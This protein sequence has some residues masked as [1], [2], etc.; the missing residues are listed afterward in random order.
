[1]NGIPIARSSESQIRSSNDLFCHGKVGSP[2]SR[3]VFL[4]TLLQLFCS[5]VRLITSVEVSTSDKHPVLCTM[6]NLVP[7]LLYWCSHQQ[8]QSNRMC[9]SHYLRHK[10]L[11]L[12]IR[13]SFHVHQETSFLVLWLQ[14]LHEY[15]EDLLHQPITGCQADLDDCLE[16]SPFLSCV[17]DGQENHRMADRHLQRQAIFL[18]LKCSIG[19]INLG[20]ETAT[21]GSCASSDSCLTNHL[22][23]DQECCT[24]KKGSVEL[25]EWLER[26]L[27]LETLVDHGMYLGK[28]RHFAIS[29]IQLYMAEDD[30]LFEVLL[31]LSSLPFPLERK[32]FKENDKVFDKVKEDVGFRLSKVFNPV[33]LFHL[34]LAEVSLFCIHILGSCYIIFHGYVS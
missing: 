16:G 26:H 24:W 10:I 29:F 27:P 32:D 31:H 7:K 30:L 13:L 23:S 25:S 21:N 19:L 9:S 28:C 1:M 15:F 20:K 4:G 2:V 22:E 3:Y 5:L 11:M 18:F 12:M 34:F 33:H 6:T 14:L 17:P 8:E